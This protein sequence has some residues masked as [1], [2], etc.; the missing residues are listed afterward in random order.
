MKMQKV[1]GQCKNVKGKSGSFNR[2]KKDSKFILWVLC[3]LFTSD[4]LLLNE[5][6]SC[7]SYILMFLH[8][9]DIFCIFIFW[10]MNAFLSRFKKNGNLL[11]SHN[12]INRNYD[13][14]FTLS[15]LPIIINLSNDINRHSFLSPTNATSALTIAFHVHQSPP[16]LL[17]TRT[18]YNVL[19]VVSQK[20]IAFL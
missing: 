1:Y 10:Q 14:C 2:S 20:Y 12:I 16:T 6:W 18:M 19:S 4:K 13:T 7:F 15:Q 9:P 8:C 3:H 11:L 17:I 5:A